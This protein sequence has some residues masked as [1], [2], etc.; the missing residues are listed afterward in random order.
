MFLLMMDD[1]MC[2]AVVYVG[3]FTHYYKIVTR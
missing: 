2:I 1:F 3:W